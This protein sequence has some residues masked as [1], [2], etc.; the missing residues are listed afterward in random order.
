MSYSREHCQES[1]ISHQVL[2]VHYPVRVPVPVT[3]LVQVQARVPV[4]V[5]VPLP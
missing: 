1:T 5:Q 2:S 3:V 4:P